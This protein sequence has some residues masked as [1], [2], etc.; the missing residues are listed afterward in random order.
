MMEHSLTV[1]SARVYAMPVCSSHAFAVSTQPLFLLII[2]C[3][4]RTAKSGG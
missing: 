4:S 3:E 1:I 2:L